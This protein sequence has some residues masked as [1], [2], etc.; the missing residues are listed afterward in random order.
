VDLYQQVV[1]DFPYSKRADDAKNRLIDLNAEVPDPN[2]AALKARPKTEERGIIDKMF[3]GV[4]GR[5]PVLS[6]TTGAGSVIEK[7][8]SGDAPFIV[9]PSVERP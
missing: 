8:P 6:N 1:S 3:S 9:N 4:F 7:K 5:G 2:P